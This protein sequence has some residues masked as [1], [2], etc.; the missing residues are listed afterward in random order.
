VGLP[1][2]RT[3]RGSR[4]EAR[5]E[6]RIRRAG[7][8]RTLRLASSRRTLDAAVWTRVRV[9][10]PSGAL[11]RIRRALRHRRAVPVSLSAIGRTGFGA[12]TP[13]ATRTLLLTR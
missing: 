2:H 1:G 7:A 3:L 6:V 12:F 13:P 8:T 11:R 10:I 5:G 4:V 9:R